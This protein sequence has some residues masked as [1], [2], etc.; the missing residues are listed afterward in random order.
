MDQRVQPSARVAPLPSEHSPE[1]KEQFELIRKTRGFIPNSSLIMQYK[2]K[3]VK[4][5]V[6]LSAAIWDP[7]SNVERG[8][9]E[10]V[11]FMASRTAGSQYCMAHTAGD[12]LQFG[13]DDRKV[14]AVFEYQTSPLFNE[15]ERAALDLAVAG[16]SVPNAA[17][18]EMFD[19]MRKKSLESL[20]FSAFS[21]GGMKPLRPRW[22][23]NPM[24]LAKNNSLG[25][26]GWP[27]S[28]SPD[29]KP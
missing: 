19:R 26:A 16:A 10:L 18:D 1:L 5:F 17:T 14:A 29:E 13:I 3:M 15:A 8:L 24:L 9:K 4:A 6:Q 25:T 23:T 21:T 27:A 22:K 11:A 12:A 7:A 2:P 28:I 20:P